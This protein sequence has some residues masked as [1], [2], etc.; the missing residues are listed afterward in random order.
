MCGFTKGETA[1]LLDVDI[2]TANEFATIYVTS[3]D[4][5]KPVATAKNLLVTAMARVRN[6]GQKIIVHS[7]VDWGRGPV[8]MEPVA[9]EINIKREGA[10]TVHILDQD[11]RR[12]G[13]T[14]PVEGR[15]VKFDTAKDK[16]V[17]YE[18]EFE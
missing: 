16:T 7:S 11:G 2:T 4:N 5:E 6:T 9:A 13:E 18:V 1:Q 10:F 15:V 12:T 17:Y 14:L 3:L 8:V